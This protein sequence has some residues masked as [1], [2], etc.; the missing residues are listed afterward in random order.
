M[1]SRSTR[2]NAWT[3]PKYLLTPRSCSSGSMAEPCPPR[4]SCATPYASPPF[5]EGEGWSPTSMNVLKPYA[6]SGDDRIIDWLAL[7]ACAVQ[8]SRTGRRRAARRARRLSL[9]RSH[10]VRRRDPLRRLETEGTDA[11]RR[12]FSLSVHQRLRRRLA[13]PQVQGECGCSLSLQVDRL[14]DRSTLV[15]RKHVLEARQGRVLTVVGNVLGRCAGTAGT[16]MIGAAD[17]SFGITAE[18]MFG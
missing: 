2:V 13:G 1:T 15:A 3:G 14:V 7:D 11:C 4:Y 10:H 16:W 5:P 17:S 18:L 6:T 8:S 9:R 12:V